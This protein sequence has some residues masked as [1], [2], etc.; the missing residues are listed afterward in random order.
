MPI[1]AGQIGIGGKMVSTYVDDQGN[2]GK[3]VDY[4]E[5]G[6]H[7]PPALRRA[8]VT[9]SAAQI[10]NLATTRVELLAADP[11]NYIIPS[12]LI[13][14]KT[15][16][17]AAP[18]EVRNTNIWIA[19]TPVAGGLFETT[20]GGPDWLTTGDG[21]LYRP[22]NFAGQDPNGW[23]RPGTYHDLATFIS[24]SGIGGGFFTGGGSSRNIWLNEPLTICGYAAPVQ[25]GNTA[26]QQWAAATAGLADL[27]L[28][29]ILLYEQVTF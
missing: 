5:V 18:A 28:R 8:D 27:Q 23:L 14:R 2:T 12:R 9:L 20:T 1:P 21:T 17:T 25:G 15:G 19:L 26:A 4:E 13:I 29:L 7:K 3:L 22:S 16:G 24:G 10:V 11:D 6:S